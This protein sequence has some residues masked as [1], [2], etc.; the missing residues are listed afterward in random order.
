[1]VICKY[2][3]ALQAR[4]ISDVIRNNPLIYRRTDYDEIG[5][6]IEYIEHQLTDAALKG[7]NRYKTV[8]SRDVVEKLDQVINFLKSEGYGV[9]YTEY[10]DDDFRYEPPYAV[11]ELDIIW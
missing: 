6:F 10:N 9:E 4:E 11:G 1:M 5:P 2:I 8:L 3:N 7:N